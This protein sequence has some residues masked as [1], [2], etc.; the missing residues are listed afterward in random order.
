MYERIDVFADGRRRRAASS[1]WSNDGGKTWGDGRAA[2]DRCR[3][4]RCADPETGQTLPQP[5]FLSAAGG[6]DGKVYVRL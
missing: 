5:G 6:R 3:S 4:C 1:K 2:S